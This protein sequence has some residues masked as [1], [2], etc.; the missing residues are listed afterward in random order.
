MLHLYFNP[1]WEY[2]RIL[3]EDNYR[4]SPA[5]WFDNQ[6]GDSY[7]SGELEQ[8]IIK[9]I[10]NSEVFHGLLMHPIYGAYEPKKLSGT[11]KTL[12]LINNE[13]DYY[14]NGAFLGENACPWLL[15]I[16]ETKDIY[17]RMAY[18]M[19]F[20]SDFEAHFV[21]TDIY[22]HTYTEYIRESASLI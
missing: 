1:P 19:P 7:I 9:D 2:D 6:G 3:T 21:N 8:K 10:D 17:I 16:A 11:T 12:L 4:I 22:T 14:Y 13:P 15:K 5:L 20:N 18:I